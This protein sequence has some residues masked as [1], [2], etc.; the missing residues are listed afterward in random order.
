MLPDNELSTNPHIADFL[1]GRADPRWTAQHDYESG[2][3][4]LNNPSEGLS[5]Q[6]WEAWI[7]GDNEIWIGAPSFTASKVIDDANISEVS[8]TFDQNMNP[9]VAYVADGIS[10]LWWLD[11]QT[12]QMT[13]TIFEGAITPR[14]SLDDKREIA[15]RGGWNDIVFAYIK[16]GNLCVRNQRERYGVEHILQQDIASS[17]ITKIGM[18]V[19]NRFQFLVKTL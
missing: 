8:L 16:D 3:I 11:S 9:C 10:K 12:N 6:V 19:I 1:G 15:T 13:T 4:A 14:V 7:N 18:S 17:G 5:V 2:G